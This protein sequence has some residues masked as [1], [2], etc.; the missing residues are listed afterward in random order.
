MAHS[1]EWKKMTSGEVYWPWDEDLQ[2]NRARCKKAC[3]LFN[4]NGEVSRREKV[5]MWRR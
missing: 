1:K 5:K 4:A 2:A 3:E